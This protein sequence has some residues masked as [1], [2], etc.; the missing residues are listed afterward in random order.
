GPAGGGRGP[1]GARA[2][3][4]GALLTKA[5]PPPRP[6]SPRHIWGAFIPHAS[7]AALGIPRHLAGCRCARPGAPALPAVHLAPPLG[8][9]RLPPIVHTG[10]RL[11]AMRP[12]VR[13]QAVVAEPRMRLRRRLPAQAA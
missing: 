7:D 8:R 13:A 5:P 9:P 12:V 3:P 10:M 6:V 11:R 2:G 1:P 4:A